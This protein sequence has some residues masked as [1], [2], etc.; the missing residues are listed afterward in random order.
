[1]TGCTSSNES[2]SD[3]EETTS[4]S[5]PRPEAGEKVIFIE[6]MPEAITVRLLKSPEGY[7]LDFST[8][9]PGDMKIDTLVSD[10]G[11]EI[12]F[13]AAFGGQVNEE[14]FFSIF[15]F[16]L[17]MAAEKAADL[18]EGAARSEGGVSV[19]AD[20]HRHTWTK[21][22]YRLEDDRQGFLLAGIHNENW[23][24]ILSAWPSVFGDGM[25]P[26]TQLILREWQWEDGTSLEP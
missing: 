17:D 12:R 18:T 11:Q 6:G 15:A 9:F 3:S 24:Y 8:Y 4:V 5:P 21:S 20:D 22:E 23:F 25:G 14:A 7:P 2:A 10:K 13:T 26:R 1:M 16:P 19:S